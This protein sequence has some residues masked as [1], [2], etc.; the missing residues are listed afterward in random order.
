M[1]PVAIQRQRSGAKGGKAA[2][3]IAKLRRTGRHENIK[4]E[5]VEEVRHDL[6]PSPLV[7]MYQNAQLPLDTELTDWPPYPCY[8]PTPTS[9]TQSS[10]GD[11]AHPFDHLAGISDILPGIN[12]EPLMYDESEGGG[13][14][15]HG[16][17]CE[18]TI[19]QG[20]CE[21]DELYS[22]NHD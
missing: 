10:V 20:R 8:Y 19:F 7:V 18:G 9:T 13:L 1:E 15:G 6:Q 11:Y 5:Q 14:S 22:G 16:A 17:Y 4:V 21:F 2:R 12:N 3:K